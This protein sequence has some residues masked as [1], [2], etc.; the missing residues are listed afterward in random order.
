MIGAIADERL[1]FRVSAIIWWDL[2]CNAVESKALGAIARQLRPNHYYTNI[3]EDICSTL[4]RFGY[5]QQKAERRT[6]LNKI[7]RKNTT[8]PKEPVNE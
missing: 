4:V 8:Q 7:R 1:R 5:N 2:F 6:G 3:E